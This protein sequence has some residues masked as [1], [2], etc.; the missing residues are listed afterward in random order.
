RNRYPIR[1]RV[2]QAA[3]GHDT[4]AG[5]RAR[6]ADGVELARYFNPASR[7]DLARG[8]LAPRGAAAPR[9][10]RWAHRHE[11]A[12]SIPWRV[13]GAEVE[14]R[15]SDRSSRRDDAEAQPR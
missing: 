9:F 13:A 5:Q 6:R 4:R 12:V 11:S 14:P 15:L 3:R 7:L 8:M 1:H 2:L 10:A